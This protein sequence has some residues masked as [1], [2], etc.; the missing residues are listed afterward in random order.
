M[1]LSIEKILW[2]LA[3]DQKWGDS[4]LIIGGIASEGTIGI[5]KDPHRHVGHRKFNE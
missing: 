3:Y 1:S 2:A 4:K 5:Y